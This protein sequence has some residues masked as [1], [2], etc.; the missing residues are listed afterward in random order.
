[1]STGG[2]TDIRGPVTQSVGKAVTRLSED[3]VS[4]L[5]RDH[6]GGDL[7]SVLAERYGIHR[8]TVSEHLR[9]RNVPARIKGLL[10]SEVE[11]SAV[12]YE[13]GYSLA[14]IGKHFGVTANTIR[15][16]LLQS[17]ARLRGPNE[18]QRGAV[19]KERQST[20]T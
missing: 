20:R 14:S 11:E 16:A 1:M 3:Q 17:G 5:V 10:P 13:E 4:R 18:L 2:V 15:N 6:M 8:V 12:L 19:P 7:V 9:R